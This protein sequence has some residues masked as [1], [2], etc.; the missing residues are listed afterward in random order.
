MRPI[1][2]NWRRRLFPGGLEPNSLERGPR[3]GA[4]A[5]ASREGAARDQ[6]EVGNR[7]T[8]APGQPATDGKPE[9]R[10]FRIRERLE[11]SFERR[12]TLPVEADLETARAS[13]G[14]G[15][16]EIHIRRT[17]RPKPR[18]VTIGK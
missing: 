5:L 17:R 7:R 8:E 9:E 14:D 12:F 1:P 18:T 4:T 10:I 2:N 15:L 3:Q 6:G 16:L 11:T 13:L